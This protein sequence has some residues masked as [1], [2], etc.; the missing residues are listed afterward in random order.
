M[1]NPVIYFIR[2]GET[3]SNAQHIRQGIYIDDYLDTRGILQ[4][5]Q[6]VP[7]IKELKL[8]VLYTS[9]L[10]RAEES[11]A[12]INQKLEKPIPIIHDR[13]LHERDFGSLAGKTQEEWEKLLPNN[14]DMEAMQEYDYRPFGGESA[15]DVR[16][17]TFSSVLDIIN[18]NP[19]KNVGIIAHNGVIRLMLFHFPEIPRIYRGKETT[20]DIA[21]ADIYEWSVTD[22]KIDSIRSLLKN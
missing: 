3:L 19:G 2:H 22:S 17:R 10:H 18:N 16:K 11:A 1:A 4:V 9:Y 14:R 21:N 8:D 20:K 7:I 15:G 6:I 13:R 12:V 5:E